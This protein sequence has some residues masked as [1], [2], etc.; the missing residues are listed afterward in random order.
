MWPQPLGHGVLRHFPQRDT[1][2]PGG[3]PQREVALLIQ[4]QALRLFDFLQA[5]S[6]EVR[7]GLAI[8]LQLCR[9]V[10]EW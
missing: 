3:F 1:R 8:G 5:N 6:Q 4:R 9:K 2:Q 10:V 7:E